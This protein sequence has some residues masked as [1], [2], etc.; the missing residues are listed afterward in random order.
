MRICDVVICLWFARVAEGCEM[1]KR[2][3]WSSTVSWL[4]DQFVMLV[5]ER[6]KRG[7]VESRV[8]ACL[9]STEDRVVL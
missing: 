9:Y 1:K 3:G 8:S 6:F 4:K 5:T 2:L 7:P